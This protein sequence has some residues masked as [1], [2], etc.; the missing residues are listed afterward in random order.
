MLIR[1]VNN[2]DEVEIYFRGAVKTSTGLQQPGENS[3]WIRFYNGSGDYYKLGMIDVYNGGH[4][5]DTNDE[6]SF[7]FCN[8]LEDFWKGCYNRFKHTKD[9]HLIEFLL[10]Q[11]LCNQ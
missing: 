11:I 2:W 5:Y 9:Q 3:L 1:K 6:G 4:S 10:T 7:T 8:S